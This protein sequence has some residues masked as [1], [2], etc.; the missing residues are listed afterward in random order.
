MYVITCVRC[1]LQ[2]VGC[3]SNALKIHIRRNLSDISS[4]TTVNLSAA[5]KHFAT[6]HEGDVT[7]FRFTGIEKV[8]RHSRDGDMRNLLFMQEAFW[9][10]TLGTRV[11]NRLNNKD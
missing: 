11:L 6:V 9:I 3:T 4:S 10:F 2:Y 7:Y 8:T 5:S 1:H